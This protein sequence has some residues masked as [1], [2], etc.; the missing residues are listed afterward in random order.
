MACLR[1]IR[2]GPACFIAGCYLEAVEVLESAYRR[3][4]FEGASPPPGAGPAQA[5]L[6]SCMMICVSQIALGDEKSAADAQSRA[7]TISVEKEGPAA[8]I[9]AGFSRGALMLARNEPIAAETSLA[10]SLK[11]ARQHEIH[12]FIPVLANQHGLA[13]LWIAQ[14][15]RAR[16]AFQTAREEAGLLGHRSAALRA[17]LGLVLCDLA[18]G[19]EHTKALELVLRCEQ[20]ARQGGYRPLELEALIIRHALL[21]AIGLDGVEARSASEALVTGD[22]S[23]RF[24]ARSSPAS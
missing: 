18:N 6:L 19:S 7:D 11:L 4:R 3:F 14:P 10:Q 13:L 22:R 16:A 8:A 23:E 9:A 24:K 21:D 12:L 15:D 1:G 2:I 17:E 5:A 20:I